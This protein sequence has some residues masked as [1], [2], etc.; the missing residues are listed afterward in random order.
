VSRHDLGGQPAPGAERPAPRASLPLSA[1]LQGQAVNL[2]LTLQPLGA[3]MGQLS[4]YVVMHQHVSS[5][6]FLSVARV[7]P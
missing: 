6:L 5:S 4:K 2:G 7:G 1:K 3:I